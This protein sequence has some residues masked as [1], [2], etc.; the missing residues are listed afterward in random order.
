MLFTPGNQLPKVRF[1]N[2]YGADKL[3]HFLIF[4]ILQFLLLLETFRPFYELK[5][6]KIWIITG[7]TIIYA[8]LSEVIQLFLINYRTGSIF[9]LLADLCG[10]TFAFG[11]ILICKSIKDQQ[12]HPIS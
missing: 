7:I 10:I 5:S 8:V 3:I 9:D 1:I 6:K 4:M 11:L 2:F 12:Y